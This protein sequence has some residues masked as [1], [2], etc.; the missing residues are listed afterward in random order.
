[1]LR[2]SLTDRVLD[3]QPGRRPQPEDFVRKGKPRWLRMQ[4]PSDPRYFALRNLIQ[5]HKLHTVC[6]EARCPNMGECWS[7]GVATVMILGDTCT[8]SCGFCNIKTGKPP[9][10][11]I[12][13]P[14]R[15]GHAVALMNLRFVCI[16][17]VNRDELADGGAS[18]WAQTL[19]QIHRQAPQTRIEALVPDFCGDWDALQLV[20]GEKPDIL[21]HNLESV[22]RLYKAVRPQAKYERSIELL[23]HA[24]ERGLVAKTGIMVGIG[25]RDEEVI[26]L[27]KD[28]Q[29]GTQTKNGACDILSIGQY[30]QPSPAHLPVNRFVTPDQFAEFKRIGEELGFRHVESGPMVRSSYHAD[31]QAALAHK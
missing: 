7:H 3:N 31:Q 21:N 27:M 30:L 6:Q 11:D 23:R 20:L 19:R 9:T 15:V 14:Q 4:L 26:A 13:E 1:M 28:V 16:T 25:E 24:K 5:E 17:S 22:P 8:R 29:A 10:L 2:V 12:D 18:L